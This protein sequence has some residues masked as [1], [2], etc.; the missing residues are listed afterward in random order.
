MQRDQLPQNEILR[1]ISAQ[2]DIEDKC[3]KATYLIDN[4]GDETQLYRESM[5]IINKIKKD[6]S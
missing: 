5:R 6:F 1:R 2:I 4:S 3:S